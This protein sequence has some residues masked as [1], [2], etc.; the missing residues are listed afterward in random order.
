[1]TQ[2]RHGREDEERAQSVA[3]L[4]YAEAIGAALLS[5]N[6]MEA[7][8]A[9]L[10]IA[11]SDDGIDAAAIEAEWFSRKLERLERLIPDEENETSVHLDEIWRGAQAANDRRIR[12]AHGILWFN[13]F[14][15]R[16]QSR[17]I[18]FEGKGADRKI[19]ITHDDSTP[20]QIFEAARCFDEITLDMDYTAASIR[21]SKRNAAS[22]P[23]SA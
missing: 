5:F 9:H 22:P 23:T 15:K 16:H 1:M 20:E 17:F 3:Y 13:P 14:E 8:L 2:D 11:L 12:L 6:A 4:E 10:V 21:R 7:A 19:V 18:T